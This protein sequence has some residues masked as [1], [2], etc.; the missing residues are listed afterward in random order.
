MKRVGVQCAE[1]ETVHHLDNKWKYEFSFILKR[2]FDIKSL[3]K[4]SLVFCNQ[5]M[6]MLPWIGLDSSLKLDTP[7]LSNQ[8]QFR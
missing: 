4:H 7:H 5:T 1:N 6:Q 8:I 3:N 2:S